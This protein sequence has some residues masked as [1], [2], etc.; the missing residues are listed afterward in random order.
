MLTT[1]HLSS[2]VEALNILKHATLQQLS[3]PYF[4]GVLQAK[5]MIALGPIEY[6]LEQHEVEVDVA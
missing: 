3:D 6:E 4:V 1:K 5:A 2:A